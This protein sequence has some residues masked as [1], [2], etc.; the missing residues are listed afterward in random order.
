MRPSP[1]PFLIAIAGGSGSGKSSITRT[2]V[3]R[4]PTGTFSVMTLDSYYRSRP[5]LAG[6]PVD[7]ANFDHP[8]ALDFPL[9]R[10]HLEALRQGVAIACPIYNFATHTREEGTTPVTPAP[11]ILV[12][13]ILA[14]SDPQLAALFDLRIFVE[15]SPDLRLIRRMK[16]DLVERNRSMDETL[17]QYLATVR[18]MH[19]EFVEPA[20]ARAHLVIH[21][22]RPGQASEALE[23]LLE[24][25]VRRPR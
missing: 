11:I 3:G 18:E 19:S 2:L 7:D 16:R 22:D 13:G 10:Q 5:D 1:P 20:R 4:F 21:N 9:L 6:S 24:F 14:L 23:R 12:D 17:N 25:A 15:A 8:E